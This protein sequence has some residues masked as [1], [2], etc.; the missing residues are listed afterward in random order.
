MSAEEWSTVI[1]VIVSG[2]LAL[3]P[4]M[5]MVHARLAVLTTTIESLAKKVDKLIDDNEQRQ[6]MCA[7]HGTRLDAVESQLVDI[8]NRLR[9]FGCARKE[10]GPT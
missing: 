6:P 1:G 5:L 2:L 8:H 9:E 3:T 10:P 7:V 4:W